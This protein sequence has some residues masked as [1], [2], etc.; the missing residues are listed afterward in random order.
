MSI[1]LDRF[2]VLSHVF[3]GFLGLVAAPIALAVSKGGAW[4]KRAGWV[5]FWCMVWIFVSTFALAFFRFNFFLL[6][7]AILSMYLALT[8]MRAL[9]RKPAAGPSALDWGASIIAAGSG[10]VLIVLS[11]AG[12][13]G[14]RLGYEVPGFNAIVGLLFGLSL[15]ASAIQEIRRFRSPQTRLA[16]IGQ[17]GGGMGGAY[18]AM[19]TAFLVQNVMRYLPDSISWLVWIVPGILATIM[20][21]R[22][23]RR[24]TRVTARS[25]PSHESD[26]RQQP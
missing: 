8:G 14:V 4:H 12:L 25:Q 23:L 24:Y 10:G 16:G 20:L 2:L 26:G 22:L 6:V 18:T 17:H 5:F 11:I 1:T 13:A 9:R 21:P 19:V 15:T 3:A 7:V